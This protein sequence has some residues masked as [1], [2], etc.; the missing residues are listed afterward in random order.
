MARVL[1]AKGAIGEIIKKIQRRLTAL[2]FDTK[3]IDGFYG[4][5][6]RDAVLLFRWQATS[7]LRERY[8]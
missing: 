5:D 1:F 6:T 8:M 4:N 2:S 3:S 7:I